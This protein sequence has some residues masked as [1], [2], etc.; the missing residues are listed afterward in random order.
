MENKDKLLRVGELAKAVKKTVRAIH[1]YEELGL[2]KPFQRTASGY[3]LYEREAIARVTWIQKLQDMGF[4]LP[5][6]QGFLKEWE[7][8]TSGPEGMA[9]VRAI[10]E[11]KLRETNE[12]I[13]RLQALETDLRESL[14]YLESCGTCEPTFVT[15]ECG[16]CNHNGHDPER[17]PDLV[18][19]LAKPATP[20]PGHGIDVPLSHLGPRE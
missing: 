3:R 4:S 7:G 8:S 16:T 15:S 13:A 17:T 12:H 10:F 2:V 11:A 9:R 6:I 19:G 14:A 1:L 18:A 5:D 20:R